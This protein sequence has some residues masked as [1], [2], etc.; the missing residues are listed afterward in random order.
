MNIKSEKT[1][2]AGGIILNSNFE[3]LVV[4]QHGRSWSLPKGHL[5][6]NESL[7][8]AAYREIEEE[9]GLTDLSYINYLGCYTRYKMDI[10]GDDDFSE[11]KNIHFFLF[12]SSETKL[13]SNDPDNPEAIWLPINE[14]SK[15]LSHP[16]DKAYFDTVSASLIAQSVKLIEI[17][18]SCAT[19]SEAKT[20]ATQLLNNKLAACC[21]IHSPITSM[22]H[23]DNNIQ[24]ESE[25]L[26]HIKS[27][28]T[29]FNAIQKIIL[30]CHSY[31]TVEILSKNIVQCQEDYARW[32]V[33]SL[34]K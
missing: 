25:A 24:E 11:E 1:K 19:E 31:D 34:K 26:L 2:S 33:N 30:D 23:W 8:D 14:V 3:V 32:V 27:T 18:C 22:F 13:S 4:S 9:T 10:N 5:E 17:N 21:Q 16:K 7:L 6:D 20:I 12:N 15:Y 29:H 28:E